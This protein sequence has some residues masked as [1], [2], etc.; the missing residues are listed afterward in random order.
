MSQQPREL[1]PFRSNRDFYGA[2]LRRLRTEMGLSLE[3]LAGKV[4]ASRAHLSRVETAQVLPPPGLSPSL[5]EFFDTGGYFARLE[6]LVRQS[7]EVHPAQFRR[8]MELERRSR[9][10]GQYAGMIVPGLLQTAAY[11]RAIFRA[12]NPDASPEEIEDKV[13]ARLGRQELLHADTP[14]DYA[15]VVDQAVLVRPVGGPAV[16]REQLARLAEAV[17]TPSTT[18]QLLPGAHGEHALMG[19]GALTLMTLDTGLPVAYEEGID[20]GTL[21]EGPAGVTARQRAYDLV[22]SYALSP[23]ETAEF[24]RSAMEELP[25][26]H[27]S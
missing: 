23:T 25:H 16:M 24:I 26:E 7:L 8:R 14:P 18:V 15:C 27:H 21:L 20:T 3:D 1:T 12:Y 10:I 22:R 13:A 19:S 2:E 9:L 5:D 11:A 4:P 17:D 6:K